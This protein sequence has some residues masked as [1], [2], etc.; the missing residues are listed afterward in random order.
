MNLQVGVPNYDGI[1][2]FHCRPTPIMYYSDGEA[3]IYGL[4][5]ARL[6]SCKGIAIAANYVLLP[7]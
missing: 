6:A 2:N 5:G 1:L 3:Y 4:W 7:T